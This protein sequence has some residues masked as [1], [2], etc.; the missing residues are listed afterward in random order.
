MAPETMK[1][2]IDQVRQRIA[3]A[4]ESCGRSEKDISLMAVTKNRSQEEI[5]EAA[6]CGISLFGE[7]RVQELQGKLSV[8][9]SRA[10]V[11]MI[12]HLQSNK[13]QAAVECSSCIQSVDRE[14]ILIAIARY[15]EEKEIV[16][17]IM[18]E[19]N[20]SGEQSKYGAQSFDEISRLAELALGR[21][22]LRLTGLMTLAPFTD[23]EY[24]VRKSFSTLHRIR[25]GLLEGICSGM[26]LMLSMGMS[27]DFE[28]AIREGSD[29]VRIGGAIFDG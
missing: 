8:F 14:K 25:T 12:G 6:D 13:V 22:H 4:A 11:H 15:A 16:F 28:P 7:N 29:L 2:R 24:E 18:L 27:H 19:A 21:K 9:P 23:D 5:L 3:R 10:E 17:D 1:Q 20:T 26:E